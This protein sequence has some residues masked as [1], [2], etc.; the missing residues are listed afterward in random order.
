[1]NDD[2]EIACCFLDDAEDVG[3][4]YNKNF[5][6]L[7]MG[8]SP[9]DTPNPAKASVYFTPTIPAGPQRLLLENGQVSM[10][11]RFEPLSG[12]MGIRYD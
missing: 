6:V 2:D 4:C 12:C 9:S 11:W 8:S 7:L 10:G 5:S 3:G 1:M